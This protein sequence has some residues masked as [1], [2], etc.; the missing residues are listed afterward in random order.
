M[1]LQWM[2]FSTLKETEDQV[3]DKDDDLHLSWMR[4]LEER[5]QKETKIDWGM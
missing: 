2:G 5:R 3:L 4:K 1:A